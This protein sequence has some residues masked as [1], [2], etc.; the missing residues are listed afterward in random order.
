VLSWYFAE[1]KKVS[2]SLCPNCLANVNADAESC[3]ACG[4]L[5]TSE[6]CRPIERE[7]PKAKTAF[8]A[9]LIVNVGL[10]IAAFGPLMFAALALFAQLMPGCVLGGSGGPAY[11]CTLIGV[12][13]NWL[14]SWATPMFVISFFTVPI[15]VLIAGAAGVIGLI[16]KLTRSG[17]R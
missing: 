12:S 6:G 9:G 13:F 15:G 5:F 10:I 14:I 1:Y 16:L 3:H 2:M 8:A 11:G 4:V 17:T 7:L